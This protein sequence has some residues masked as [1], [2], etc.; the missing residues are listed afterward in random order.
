MIARLAEKS[1][2]ERKAAMV[3]RGRVL[4]IVG[5]I[6]FLPALATTVLVEAWRQPA[7][8]IVFGFWVI[9][10]VGKS[11]VKFNS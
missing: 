2:P 9:F 8:A 1:S 6:G 3:R 10:F 4:M 7:V 11:L 5:L